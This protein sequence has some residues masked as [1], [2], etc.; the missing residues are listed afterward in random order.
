M[1]LIAFRSRLRDDA[2]PGYPEK[3]D[4]MFAAAR[5]MPG[6]VD[7]R[8]YEAADGERLALVW[9]EDEQSLRAWRDDPAHLEAQR[10]GRELWYA[11]YA[12]DVASIERSS[13]F[14]APD[15]ES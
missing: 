8:A 11:S 15:S 14:P 4:E 1:K 10:L 9:W 12:L 5:A 13:R 2:G 3:A 7:F 6:F